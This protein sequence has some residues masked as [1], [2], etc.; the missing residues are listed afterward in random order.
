LALETLK[1]KPERNRVR[2]T[3]A[4][5]ARV[6]GEG[7]VDGNNQIKIMSAL[8]L[9]P[10]FGSLIWVGGGGVGL[11]LLIVIIVLLVR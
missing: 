11:I 1:S 10:L 4:G 2:K 3:N 5:G 8:L 9:H 6:H 7:A